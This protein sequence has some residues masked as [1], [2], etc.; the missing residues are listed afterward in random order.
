MARN[1]FVKHD[2]VFLP[3]VG[4]ATL[5]VVWHASVAL[6]SVSPVIL[7]APMAVV[8]ELIANWDAI[9]W[10]S[11]IT[12]GEATG[13]FALAAAVGLIGAVV[14]VLFQRLADAFFPLV[15][16]VK[17]IPMI[18][19]APLIVVWFG[20]GYGSKVIMAA[21]VAFFP[22]LIN[23]LRGL[24]DVGTELHDL[25]ATLSATRTQVLL[26]LRLPSA[27]AYTFAALRVA[28]VFAVIGAVVAEFIGANAG[29]GYFVKAASYYA[30]TARMMAGIVATA[31]VGACLYG[32]VLLIERS[33]PRWRWVA[34]SETPI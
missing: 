1:P 21:I 18:A 24:R 20:T 3:L 23:A 9:L 15:V 22:I 28:A 4:A 8:E 26:R 13:G 25:F 10:H 7:P 11:A 14:F 31:A 33:S 6:T 29:I 27:V 34:G 12:F 30:E 32:I 16:A 2:R 17:M 5:V 19:L